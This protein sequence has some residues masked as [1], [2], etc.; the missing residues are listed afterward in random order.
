ML[1]LLHRRVFFENFRVYSLSSSSTSFR[2]TTLTVRW[3]WCHRNVSCR[4]LLSLT[5]VLPLT[6]NTM[7]PDLT[8]HRF[9]GSFAFHCHIFVQITSK[10]YL[11]KYQTSLLLKSNHFCDNTPQNLNWPQKAGSIVI[12]LCVVDLFNFLDFFRPKSGKSVN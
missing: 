11:F 10:I 7:E 3:R 5:F 8:R 1:H 6:S 4:N 2:A 9:Q 12:P